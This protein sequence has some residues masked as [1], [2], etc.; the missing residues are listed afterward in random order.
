MALGSPVRKWILMYTSISR[1][2]TAA[3]W[4]SSNMNRSCTQWALGKKL[5]RISISCLYIQIIILEHDV[6]CQHI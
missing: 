4:S 1:G 2:S 6:F 5:P 3:S